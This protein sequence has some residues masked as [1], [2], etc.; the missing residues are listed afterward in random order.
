MIERQIDRPMPMPFGLRREEGIEQLTGVRGVDARYRIPDLN[1]Y[2][3]G[4]VRLGA[5]QVHGAGRRQRPWLEC[6]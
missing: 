5:D 4:V 2:L 3:S 1:E 6:R